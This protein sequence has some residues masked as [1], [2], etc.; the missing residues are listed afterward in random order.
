M[1]GLS[2]KMQLNE[3]QHISSSISGNMET[4]EYDQWQ[5]TVCPL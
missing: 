2:I 4:E 5:G 3:L 1:F